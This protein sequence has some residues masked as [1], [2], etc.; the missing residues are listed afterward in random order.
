M[1]IPLL[2]AIV[3]HSSPLLPNT[4]RLPV[5]LNLGY[6]LELPTHS[7]IILFTVNYKV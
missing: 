7:H 4:T 1:W 3:P 2:G 6:I 5:S